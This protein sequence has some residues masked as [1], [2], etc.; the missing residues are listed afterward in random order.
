MARGF[1]L[2]DLALERL[3]DARAALERTLDLAGDTPLTEA[4]C[5]RAALEGL[6]FAPFRAR[7]A[8]RAT[9]GS[10]A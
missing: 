10:A 6:C 2:N 1:R 3:E 4:A 7:N 9:L 5:A 8:G